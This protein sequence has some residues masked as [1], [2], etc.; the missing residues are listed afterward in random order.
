M[1]QV[2]SDDDKVG[3]LMVSGNVFEAKTQTL[4]WIA[5]EQCRPRLNEMQIG[6]LD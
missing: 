1:D 6:Y 3:I 5:V 4:I 2:T